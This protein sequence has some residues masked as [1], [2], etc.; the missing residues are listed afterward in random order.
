MSWEHLL[1]FGAGLGT[2]ALSW[3]M[4]IR[5]P[6]NVEV[7]RHVLQFANLPGEL[8]GRR[9]VFLS[10]L[11]HRNQPGFREQWV[12][13][14]IP[15]LK[16]DILCLGGDLAEGLL[17]TEYVLEMIGEWTA[18]LGKYAV[19]GNNE[20]KHQDVRG[21]KGQLEA[22]GVSVLQN[23]FRV[24]S[25]GGDQ[26]VMAGVDD[27]TLGFDDLERTMRHVPPATFTIMLSHSPEI[28]P[29][30][31]ERNIPLTLCGHTHGGQV[32]FPFVGALWTDTPKTGLRYQHGLYWEGDSALV[33]SKGVGTSKLPIR[34]LS[35]PEVVVIDLEGKS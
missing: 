21:F 26:W 29:E 7:T 1:G 11:H 25:S 35:R 5:A 20:H 4:L 28:F 9:I 30:I 8:R 10:D 32:R 15:Q 31:A 34:L 22:R 19:M 12:R 3:E 16:P 2:L 6:E 17:A 24:C 33:L 14:I 13:G 23:Q 18:P 27:P